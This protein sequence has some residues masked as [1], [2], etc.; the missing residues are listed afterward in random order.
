MCKDNSEFDVSISDVKM[1]CP[2][3]EIISTLETSLEC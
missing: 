3:Y 1:P 2:Y